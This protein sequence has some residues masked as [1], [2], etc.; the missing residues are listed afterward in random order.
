MFDK[1]QFMGWL[2]IN[3]TDYPEFPIIR[4]NSFPIHPENRESPVLTQPM[5]VFPNSFIVLILQD[6]FCPYLIC[7]KKVSIAEI[8]YLET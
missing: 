3:F 4:E 1:S 5:L 6:S 7:V 2:H 8:S